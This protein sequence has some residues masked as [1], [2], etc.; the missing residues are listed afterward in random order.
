MRGLEPTTPKFCL[1]VALILLIT[2][3]A[4]TNVLTNMSNNARL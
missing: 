4:D 1:N 2:T 3:Q